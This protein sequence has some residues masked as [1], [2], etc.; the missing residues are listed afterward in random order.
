MKSVFNYSNAFR[1]LKGGKISLVV[2]AFLAGTTIVSASPTGGVVTSGNAIISQNGSNT[3]INQSTNKASINWQNFNIAG[4]ETVNFIQPSSNSVTLNRVVGTTNSLIQGAMNANGQVILINPNGVIFSE[5]ASVNVGGLIATTKNITDANFQNGNYIFEGDSTSSIL[6]KGTINAKYVAMMGKEV[7]NEGKIV[8]TLGR[9]ELAGGDK[10]TLNLNGDSLLKLTIDEGTLNALVENKGLIK[11]DGGVVYLTTQ[12][13]DSVLDGMVNNSGIIEAQSLSANEKGEIVLFAHGGTANI[14]GTIKAEGGFIETSGKEFKIQPNATI[15]AGEWLIDPV[16]ITI[17]STLAGTISTAL[18]SG[19]VTITTS[20]SCTGVTCSGTGSDGDITVNSG[21]SWSSNNDLTLHAD[22]NIAINADITATGASAKVTLEYGQ[23]TGVSG[24]TAKYDFGLTSAGFTGKI[25]LQAGQ[26]F[27]T[28]LGNDSTPIDYTV[29]TSLGNQNDATSAPGTMTL[30]GIRTNLTG[31]YVLGSNINA[32][33]TSSW[34]DMTIGDIVYNGFIPLSNGYSDAGSGNF[35]TTD[36]FKGSFVGLGHSISNLSI[37][38]TNASNTGNLSNN[39]GL[40]GATGNAATYIGHFALEHSTIKGGAIVGGAVGYS[41]SYTT[42]DNIYI[43]SDVN[44]ISTNSTGGITGV[45]TGAIGATTVKNSHAYANIAST[46]SRVGGLVGDSWASTIKDSFSGGT[47]S[48]VGSVGGAL[49]WIN[50]GTTASHLVSSAT[51]TGTQDGIGGVV[52]MA[53]AG[54]SVTYSSASGNVS[55]RYSVGGFI[56]SMSNT[57]V[58]YS[59]ATGT[60]SGTATIGGF[61]GSVTGSGTSQVSHSYSTGSVTCAGAGSQIGG[62][63]GSNSGR[64]DESYSTGNVSA[65]S[66]S[67]VGGFVGYIS[68]NP[69]EGPGAIYNSYSTG[70][71]TGGS[72]VGGFVGRNNAGTLNSTTGVIVNSYSTGAVTGSSNAGAFIGVNPTGGYIINSFWNTDNTA[73]AGVGSGDSTNVTLLGK[74]ASEMKAIALFSGTTPAWEIVTDSSLSNVYPQLRWATSG[75]SAGTSVWVIGSSE[76]SLSYNF[77]TL[78]GTYTY[79]GSAYS[80]ADYWSAESIFGSTYSSW[81]AG[82]D[83]DFVYNANT[84]TGFKN[85]GT[86]SSIGIDIL[87]TGFTEATSGN[88]NGSFTIIPKTLTASLTG[89]I[90]KTYDGNTNAALD[91]SN[92]RVSGFVAGEDASVTERAGTYNFKDVSTANSVTA[93]LA[94]DDFNAN[95]ETLLSNYTL[96]TTASGDASITTKILTIIGTTASDKVYDGTMVAEVNLGTLDGF[97]GSE[98]V[99]TT[100]T[101]TFSSKDTGTRTATIAYTLENGTNGGL[102]SN[103]SLANTTDDAVIN[104]ANVTYTTTGGTKTYG[105]TFTLPTPTFTGG[106]PTGTTTVKVYDSNNVDVTASAIAG[107]LGAGTYSVKTLLTDNNYDIASNGNTDGILTINALP[108]VTPPSNDESLAGGQTLQEQTVKDIITNIVNNTTVQTVK[109][110]N[111]KVEV[112]VAKP[113][114]NPTDGFA[115]KVES[116]ISKMPEIKNDKSLGGLSLGLN[117]VIRSASPT[118]NSVAK[119]TKLTVVGETGGEGAIAKVELD[120]LIAKNGGGE[121]RVALSPDSFVE[122]VNGGVNLPKGVSQEFYVVEDKQ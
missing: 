92:Y 56:G 88:T 79:K 70:S 7:I 30:Q 3:T 119:E 103:Y 32:S 50:G 58:D 118:T 28:K 13:L 19:D 85:A 115:R 21:I 11:A 59:Y 82:T 81:I 45:T 122:L 107:T 73:L 68:T 9:V 34:G 22:R 6:N 41:Y 31:N 63:A 14:G 35:S 25:N 89:T 94:S 69:W 117:E 105:Q 113:I 99:T 111:M 98:S 52:G 4:N 51:V 44:L 54:N 27:S 75:L 72:N 78:A 60:V 26:N 20:G 76:V 109:P 86:Y 80:L 84:V 43:K 39:A 38:L 102:A 114:E 24:N 36:Q 71:V 57:T 37:D 62:F 53:S 23:S 16:N 64:I 40:F 101:G 95:N 91:A 49:G 15:K 120:E 18:G 17:D 96:P 10:F 100:T 65:S 67:D 33:A 55:G 48:G 121:L 93:T 106:T 87:R 83:Y 61:A 12:A 77:S 74:T 47:I 112:A 110:D 5:G 8:A 42:L 104:K 66:S 90:T 29:I 46:G 2:S 108:V 116:S 97:V 1:I